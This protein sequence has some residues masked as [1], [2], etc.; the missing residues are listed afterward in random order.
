M[1]TKSSMFDTEENDGREERAGIL[2]I[3]GIHKH[4]AIIAVVCR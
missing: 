1:F 2:D 4:T 3:P